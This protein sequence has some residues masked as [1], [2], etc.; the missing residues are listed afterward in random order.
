M[1][2]KDKEIEAAVSFAKP[3]VEIIKTNVA[4]EMEQ[5]FLEY[6]Y[7][8]IYARALP[9]ARDG[10]KP[11]HRRILYSMVDSGYTPDKAHVKSA[12]IVGA[13]MG[14]LHPHG[15]CLAGDTLIL[16][17]EGNEHS[18]ASLCDSQQTVRVSAVNKEGQ[19]I[20][21]DAHSFRIG[22]MAERLYHITMSNGHKITATNNHPFLAIDGSWIKA[23]QLEVG[24]G[25]RSATYN[26]KSPRIELDVNE[27]ESVI[28]EDLESPVPMYDFTVDEHSNLFIANKIGDVYSLIVAHNSAIYESMVRMAQPF[29]MR[30]VLVDGHGNFGGTP[31]DSAASARYTESRLSKEGLAFIG[32]IKEE[33]VDFVPNFD[34]STTQPL[35][36]PATFPNLLINGTSGI[37][38][39]MATNMPPHNP[40]EAIKAAQALVKNPEM[41]LEKLMSIIPGPDFPTGGVIMGQD[42]LKDAYTNGKGIIKIRARI[43][44][45]VLSG[46]KHKL[47]VKEHPYATGFEKIIES[48]KNEISKKRVQGITRVI[49]LTD[50]RLGTHLV[51]E[52]KNGFNPQTVISSLYRYTPLEISFG[53]QNLALVEGQPKYVG[54]KEMLEIFINHRRSVITRRT[55]F[56]KSKREA[57]LHLVTGLIK[58][59]ADIDKAISI[60]RNADDIEVARSGLMGHF[61]ID[62]IQGDY[63][64][65]L[66]LRR[67]TKY[68]TMELN[69]ENEKLRKEIAELDEILGSKKILDELLVSELEE[70]LK[71]VGDER[72]S[73]I[74]TESI[75]A[76]TEVGG[77][78]VKVVD[79][80]QADLPEATIY[81]NNKGQLLTEPTGV[82]T[83]MVTYKGT[84][85]GISKDGQAHRMRAGDQFPGLIALAPDMPVGVIAVGTKQGIVKMVAPNYPTRNDDFTIISLAPK[86]E[87]VGAKWVSD[88]NVG[89]AVFITSDSSLLKFP[90][91]KVRAQGASA[92]GV[93]GIKLAEGVNVISFNVAGEDAI[94]VTYTG[95]SVK[96]TP[97]KLYPAKGRATGGVRSHKF[98]KGETELTM[99][100]VGDHP[101]GLTGVKVAK[102]PPVVEKRDGSGT[103]ISL[104][105]IVNTFNS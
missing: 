46:G 78:K 104:T 84:F 65:S 38:V 34:G 17:I 96:Q 70:V 64:L 59:L 20:V 97:L 16:D 101:A 12:R 57:R 75:E 26:P 82:I 22:Q 41:T 76:Y 61:A 87:I 63:I 92:A 58:V 51:I 21:A 105:S 98:L 100:V 9:D 19:L 67:L 71:L 43:D 93:A 33:A 88:V 95:S 86:D 72:R 1:A 102:L 103:S 37:A 56:R 69:S 53:I 39:G 85:L 47:I 99:S 14:T 18:L 35:V 81:M 31:D 68:D 5:S 13:V 79:S 91:S 52:L 10:L 45:E 15:D 29:S 89:E 60:I 66:Q 32:E 54:L 2:K 4:E 7:S 73:E 44:V 36:L 8:V 3:A 90:V 50:R 28:I 27:V 62:D 49:D 25:L 30:T 6:S 48:I 74:S 83:D 40:T 11:V 80:A 77:A 55:E 94:V 24:M 23:D 42:Q